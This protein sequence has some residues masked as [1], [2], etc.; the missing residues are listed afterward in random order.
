MSWQTLQNAKKFS[1]R[2]FKH[3]HRFNPDVIVESEDQRYWKDREDDMPGLLGHYRKT[4]N[5]RSDPYKHH[6]KELSKPDVES[7]FD[8]KNWQKEDDPIDEYDLCDW[9]DE[10]P[11]EYMENL[12]EYIYLSTKE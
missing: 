1:L 12:L 10:D 9:M 6:E 11:D 5:S 7:R 4:G 2:R 3:F 8:L